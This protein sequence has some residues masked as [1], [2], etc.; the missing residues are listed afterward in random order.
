MTT[1]IQESLSALFADQRFVFWHD[2][3]SQFASDIAELCSSDVNLVRL[4]ETPALEIKMAVEADSS[5]GKW[6]FYSNQAQVSTEHDWLLD[7]RMRSGEFFADTT[8]LLHAELGLTALSLRD[9][10]KLRAKYLGAKDR[11]ARFKKMVVP[12]DMEADIDRKI[13][14]AI[15]RADPPSIAGIM[16]KL[17]TSL[18]QNGS[19]DLDGESKAWAELCNF[20]MQPSFWTMAQQEFGY[21]ETTASLRDLLFRLFVTDFERSIRVNLPASLQHLVL[22][23]V[24]KAANATVFLSQWRSNIAYFSSY[25]AISTVVADELQLSLAISHL[26]AEDLVDA[27]GFAEIEKAIVKDLRDRIESGAGSSFEA[28]RGIFVVRRDGHWANSKMAANSDLTRSL[29]CCYTALEAAADLFSLQAKYC[30]G[31]SFA[32][33]SDAAQL[34]QAELFRF[35]QC[36]RYFNHAA[37]QVELAGWQLL[38]S[39]R[40]KVEESYTGWFIPQLA[41]SWGKVIEGDQGLLQDW[42]LP[43]IV[44]QVDFYAREVKPLLDNTSVK[45]VFVIISDALRYEAAEELCR[46][47]V[48]RNRFKATLSSMLSVLPSYTSLGMAALLPHKT[49][50]YKDNAYL[51]VMVD[52]MPTSS[53]LERNAVLSKHD[54]VAINWEDLIALG[55]EKAFEHVRAASVVYVYH[56]RIDLLGDKAAS[57]RKTFEAVEDTLKELND[58]LHFILNSLKASTVLVT[59]DHGFMYQESALDIA[60]KSTLDI[61]VDGVLKSKKRYVLGKNL[62]ATDKAWYGSTQTT[63]GT[64]AGASLDFWIPKGAT[65]FHFAGGARFVHGSAMPQEVI[66]PL[67]TVKVSESDKARIT[68]INIAPLLV[69]QKIVNNTQRFEFIQTEPTSDK[70]LARSV[71]VYLCDGNVLISNKQT[72]TFDSSSS[73]M[74]DW[75]KS[76]LLTVLSGSYDPKKDFYLVMFDIDKKLELHRIPLKIDLALAND[77]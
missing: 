13:I 48:N 15:V 47:I 70:V 45:R 69:S 28:I 24:V 33:A 61:K 67:L 65:R 17:V 68:S 12:E 8:S 40:K 5:Q 60:D 73:S 34:Y 22:P 77:F 51:S 10:L 27:M 54:G 18:E 41:L 21:A 29:S 43:G 56:D 63:A 62:G 53:T 72:V 52:G 26:H 39:L 32:L 38:H 31:F 37:D 74:E 44:K 3:E 4:D 58:L 23:D 50:A 49:M 16:L 1:K 42:T 6:L 2:V 9:H 46:D 35:D 55:K 7:I 20:G 64:D 76:I 25:N 71:D 75:K 11:L 14:A 66:V 36:Y 59:A 19:V 57:E 30:E